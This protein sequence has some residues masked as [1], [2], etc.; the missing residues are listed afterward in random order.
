MTFE[1]MSPSTSHVQDQAYRNRAAAHSDC[2]ADGPLSIIAVGSGRIF[3]L[4]RQELRC[5]IWSA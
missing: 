2:I 5:T 1:Q 3:D 4:C